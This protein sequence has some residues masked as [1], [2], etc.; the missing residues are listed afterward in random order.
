MDA[1]ERL[2]LM[3]APG[4]PYT[5][6]MLAVL[7]YRHI[8][9]RILWGGHHNPP[10]GYPDP[11]VKLLPTFYFPAQG[12]GREALVDSTPII[13]RLERD[14]PGREV[15]PQE[16]ELAFYN[17]LIEDFADEW[18]TKAMF[19]YRWYHKADR[20]NAG[21]LLAYWADNT[22]P[23]E[24]ADKAAAKF[25]QRQFER[26]HVVGSNDVTART[27]EASF[28]RLVDI[29]DA[30]LQLK[31]YVLGARPASA[32]F[33]I[34]GQ[35]TQLGIIEP[36]SARVL[37]RRS[38]RLRAWLD[39]VEDL[40]GLD[41]APGDWFTPDEARSALAPLLGEI[42]RVYVPFLLANAAAGA[43]GEE[44]W[45]AQIDGRPWTQPTFPYQV[46]CL[47]ALREARTA[48]PANVRE[49]V[50]TTLE[51]AGCKALFDQEG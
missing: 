28:E 19:H 37:G 3:G 38:P 15:I 6:K 21:P 34:H 31:G 10:D 32:D 18:L 22:L 24:A 48:L 49:A 27:I 17:D 50:D 4:S 20:D 25:T 35:L 8:P 1:A 2:E 11:K 13:R 41:P 45:Q 33:A 39:R 9:Y 23:A 14:Y 42:G 7:R 46:K 51:T 47:Q 36:T 26:L 5:R 12:G 30:L 44:S 16:R 43:A 40:S 29:L